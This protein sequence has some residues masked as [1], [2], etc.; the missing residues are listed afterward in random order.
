MMAHFAIWFRDS[1]PPRADI[2]M[3]VCKRDGCSTARQVD[4]LLEG[5]CRPCWTQQR[6][7]EDGIATNAAE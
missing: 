7:I 6:A 1:T 2:E 5:Y 3:R 4:E